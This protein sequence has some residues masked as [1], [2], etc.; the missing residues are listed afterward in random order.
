MKKLIT[1]IILLLFSTY[2]LADYSSLTSKE[3]A[4]VIQAFKQSKYYTALKEGKDYIQILSVQKVKEEKISDNKSHN[5][6]LIKV[7]LY[8][9][10]KRFYRDVTITLDIQVNTSVWTKWD[11]WKIAGALIAGFF[12]GKA[13]SK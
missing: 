8:V 3:R 4:I 11:I 6:Y 10:D 9:L 2:L 7:I 12:I 1:I 5:T 13:A